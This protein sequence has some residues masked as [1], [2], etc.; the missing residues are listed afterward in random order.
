ML[1]TVPEIVDLVGGIDAEQCFPVNEFG[2]S[3]EVKAI[4]ESIF[5]QILLSS[6]EEI[7]EIISRLKWRLN[8]EKKV[9]SNYIS[10]I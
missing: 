7:C 5:S 9:N 2:R 8:L 3:Q 1:C 4:V 10:A 6:K